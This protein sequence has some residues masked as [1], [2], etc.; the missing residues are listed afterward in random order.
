MVFIF[1]ELRTGPSEQEQVDREVKYRNVLLRYARENNSVP[2]EATAALLWKGAMAAGGS[3]MRRPIDEL[4]SLS[5]RCNFE[6]EPRWHAKYSARA[7]EE[8][9]I[10][11]QPQARTRQFIQPQTRIPEPQPKKEYS[12]E[13]VRQQ[14]PAR[15][16]T[17]LPAEPVRQSE[18]PQRQYVRPSAPQQQE[19]GN[20][21]QQEYS[22][23]SMSVSSLRRDAKDRI[24]PPTALLGRLGLIE[25]RLE[26]F[27]R[28]SSYSTDYLDS[29]IIE[30]KQ[31]IAGMGK[32]PA[33][34]VEEK[35]APRIEEKP[36]GHK[37]HPRS[38]PFSRKR[39]EK[40]RVPPVQQP[41]PEPVRTF[42]PN[43]YK[44]PAQIV[45][46]QAVQSLQNDYA[47]LSREVSGMHD[48]VVGIFTKRDAAS[49]PEAV[50]KL[51]GLTQRCKDF[52]VAAQS[53]GAKDFGLSLSTLTG[54]LGDVHDY[55]GRLDAFKR[56]D[57]KITIG[58]E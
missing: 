54:K 38:N 16:Y 1:L 30:L 26:A 45:S 37:W 34:K 10:T 39:T 22:R 14:P 15:E 5:S 4:R 56:N 23:I 50:E 33:Q 46:P 13:P 3:Y 31:A 53:A 24:Y 44:K 18:P 48:E 43:P 11:E 2:D 41:T 35:P 57:G 12:P 28:K 20:S 52:A 42:P 21:E 47:Q 17:R 8:L 29:A 25:E 7:T 51:E 27:K 9:G 6:P 40:A 19:G 32:P 58:F 55:L 49:F 36:E